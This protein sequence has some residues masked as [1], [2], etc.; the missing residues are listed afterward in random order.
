[1]GFYFIVFTATPVAVATTLVVEVAVEGDI[2]RTIKGKGKVGIATTEVMEEVDP[3]TQT[4]DLMMTVSLA[5]A[6]VVVRD[7]DTL[8]PATIAN[9]EH[10]T[11]KFSFRQRLLL[12]DITI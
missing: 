12:L 7:K 6:E 10:D 5:V 8:L 3:P 2:R 11:G 1:M 4:G 9:A